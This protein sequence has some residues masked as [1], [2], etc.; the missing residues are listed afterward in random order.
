MVRS[1]TAVKLP[2]RSDPDEVAGRLRLLVTRLARVL[3]HQGAES[4]VPTLSAA[5][6]TI[7]REGPL[8]LGD[9]AAREHVAPPSI[10]KAVDKL[11]RL[12]F[13]ERRQDEIDRRVTRVQVTSEGHRHLAKNR[14]Q[15][16]VWLATRLRGLPAKDL[17]ILAAAADVLER[18][19]ERSV[20]EQA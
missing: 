9:L 6:A 11:E 20:A 3:R 18:L 14:S 1:T 13:V 17:E 7:N 16:T 5:L 10:T 19:I 12:G 8:T 2:R 15:R 4:L